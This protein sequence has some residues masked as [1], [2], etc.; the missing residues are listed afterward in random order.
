M[1]VATPV[2][3]LTAHLEADAVEVT[4][5]QLALGDLEAARTFL[6][7]GIAQGRFALGLVGHEALVMAL[8]RGDG[9]SCVLQRRLRHDDRAVA[10]GIDVDHAAAGLIRS[11][12]LERRV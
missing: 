6:L 1:I 5:D 2:E 10:A 11:I 9:A 8:D 12:R 3:E 4:F 7:L